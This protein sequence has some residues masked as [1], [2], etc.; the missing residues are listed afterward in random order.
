M[1]QPLLHMIQLTPDTVRVGLWIAAEKLGRRGADEGYGWHAILK[2]AFGQ[3][4]PKPFR[5][6]ERPRHPLQLLGYTAAD[7]TELRDHASAFTD[8][9][10]AAALNVEGLAVKRM[11]DAFLPGQRL[12]FEVR[13]RP[14]IRQH[15]GG[16]RTKSRERD[17]FLAEIEKAGPRQTR[18][19]LDRAVV[20]SEWLGRHLA[21]SGAKLRE[22]RAVAM[23]RTHVSRRDSE[24]RLK[25]DI[26]GPDATFVG[27]LEITEPEQFRRLLARGVGRHRAFGYGMLLL[28]PPGRS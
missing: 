15:V 7:E 26:E 13:I 14:T 22:A 19:D 27:T 18:P 28:K 25:S 6:I 23:R 1:S 2:A 10:V 8:P 5:L 4:A 20:Y 3:H 17:A 24:R 12:A 9:T 11:P 21:A 16:D